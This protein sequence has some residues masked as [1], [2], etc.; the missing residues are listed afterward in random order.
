MLAP[1]G[2]WDRSTAVSSCS[3]AH[4]NSFWALELKGKQG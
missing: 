3:L 2:E 4:H 1:A